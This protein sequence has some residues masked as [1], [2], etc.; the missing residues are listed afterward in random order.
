[1]A[2]IQFQEEE[3]DDLIYLA[4]VGD[5]DELSTLLSGIIARQTTDRIPTPADVLAQAVD[6]SSKNT[7]LHM[8]SANGHVEIVE[9]ILSRFPT[10]DKD[11]KQAFLDATN[12][13][14]N[15][16]LHW[17][18]LN[19]H[20]PIVKLLVENGASVALANDKNYI[21]L[22]L[23]SFSEKI[24]VVDYFL[25]EVREMEAEN[26]KEGLGEAVADVKVED[27]EENE[28]SSKGKEKESS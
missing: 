23:A 9:Y 22:D 27:G 19:G 24:D 16:A 17:A 1:M 18:A 21:P 3:I 25:K 10:T 5:K 6:E 13:F 20:L 14:G 15:T 28:G 4:R 8:A 11:Q 12:E 2:S 7:T 26:A